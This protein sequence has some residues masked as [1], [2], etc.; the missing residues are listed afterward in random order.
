MQKEDKEDKECKCNCSEQLIELQ[1]KSLEIKSHVLALVMEIKDRPLSDDNNGV[2]DGESSNSG[3]KR[4]V[5]NEVR[6]FMLAKCNIVAMDDKTEGEMYDF[7]VEAIWDIVA[8]YV[9]FL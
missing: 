3:I 7:A 9:P 2:G 6:K 1:N 5:K 8:K 4:R